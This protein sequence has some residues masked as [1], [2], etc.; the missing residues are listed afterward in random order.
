[1]SQPIIP[2]L[3]FCGTAEAAVNFYVSI[4]PSSKINHMT[5]VGK[6]E[7]GEEGKVFHSSFELKGQPLMA[8]DMEAAY[9][10]AFTWA[11]SLYMECPVESEFDH[12]FDKLSAE[13]NVLMGPEPVGN[14]RK[15]AWVSDK[16]GVT[17]KLFLK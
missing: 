14:L 5:M 3:T 11:I 12:L 16:F 10:P 2:F 17:W 7:R 9:C 8:M 6:N 1:M 15:V 4:F 13:G